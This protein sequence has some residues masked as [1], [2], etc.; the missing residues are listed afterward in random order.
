ME[1]QG[2][3]LCWVLVGLGRVVNH[4]VQVCLVGQVEVWGLVQED[5]GLVQEDLDPVQE[6]LDSLEDLAQT[7]QVG[8][9]DRH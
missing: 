2:E 7:T 4:R 9:L 8:L 3:A 1:E 5:L 6:E